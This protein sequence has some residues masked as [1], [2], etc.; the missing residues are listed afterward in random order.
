MLEKENK[1]L[2]QLCTQMES[3]GVQMEKEADEEQANEQE[4][5]LAAKKDLKD[6][7]TVA[8][9]DLDKA[10]GVD[11]QRLNTG[12]VLPDEALQLG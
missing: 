11:L 4:K 1:E 3:E 9:F 5:H 6:K 12:I 10:L 7:I 8:K 2:D